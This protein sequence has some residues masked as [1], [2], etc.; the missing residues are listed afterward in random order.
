MFTPRGYLAKWKILG[1]ASTLGLDAPQGMKLDVLRDIY[2]GLALAGGLTA[3]AYFLG[4]AAGEDVEVGFDPRSKMFGKAKVGETTYDFFSGLL[5][6]I[7]DTARLITGQEVTKAGGEYNLEGASGR[8]LLEK[9]GKSE[10][11]L[12]PTFNRASTSDVISSHFR[13]QAA[14]WLTATMNALKGENGIGQPYTFERFLSDVAEPLAITNVRKGGQGYGVSSA[15]RN[16][17]SVI[18][19]HTEVDLTPEEEAE[20]KEANKPVYSHKPSEGKHKIKHAF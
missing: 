16:L 20:R 19:G 9:L 1:R 8:K 7:T 4:K 10:S 18:G 6:I 2:G 14:P 12:P 5:P 15:L 13:N 11:T 17:P 3:S